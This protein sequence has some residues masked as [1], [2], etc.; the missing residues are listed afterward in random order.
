TMTK[1][2]KREFEN[3]GFL[4][5]N[6]DSFACNL[7]VG[8]LCDEFNR[9]SRI[10]NDMFTYETE[11][12]KPSQCDKQTSNPTHN[13]LKEY[14]WKISYNEC[15]KIYAEAVIF[16]NKRL[17]KLIDVIVEQWLNLK[18]ENH[19]TMDE[20][21]KKGVISSWLIRSY[22]LPFEE[23]LEIMK[24]RDTYARDARGDDEVELS[25]EE[26]SDPDD[27]NL[28]DK[29][30]V[31]EIFRIETNVFDFETPTCRA[32]K[33]FNYFLQIDP[34]VLTKDIDEFKT[35]E[36]YKDDW[37][38]EWNEDIPWS[39]HSK[40]PTC[41]WKDDGYCNGGNM[42]GAFKVRNTLRYQDLEWYESLEDVKLKEE[43]LLNKAIMN[44]TINEEEESLEET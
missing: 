8:T 15:K 28:N 31:A 23:Y 35:Y 11:V 4:E 34:D 19:I 24:Q 36:E 26:S 40:W 44:G 18:Y 39:G 14:E 33:E 27:E 13:D 22:K 6:D 3:L 37:I 20:N 1:V 30:E 5:I 16:V 7:Q 32:F 29:D 9:L 41:S 2:I 38:Y 25:D 43:A 10:D 12:P 42:P 17:V 21:I